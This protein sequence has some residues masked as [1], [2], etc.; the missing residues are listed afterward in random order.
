[1]DTCVVDHNNSNSN[2]NTDKQKKIW[3][4]DSELNA[5]SNLCEE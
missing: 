3:N 4:S 5:S 2:N 1:M